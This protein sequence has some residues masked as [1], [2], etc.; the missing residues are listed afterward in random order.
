[1]ERLI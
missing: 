1:M